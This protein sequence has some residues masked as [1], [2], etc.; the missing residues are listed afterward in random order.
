[1]FPSLK[2]S[3]NSFI[4]IYL[5]YYSS[6]KTVFIARNERDNRAQISPFTPVGIFGMRTVRETT[7]VT[8]SLSIAQVPFE[9]SAILFID[10]SVS[11]VR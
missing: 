8:I 1:M 11:G 9:C 5:N 7:A 6:K 10:D 2:Y 4:T 3:L